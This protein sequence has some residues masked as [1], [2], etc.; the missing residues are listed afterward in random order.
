MT[1]GMKNV[2][3][4]GAAALLAAVA[5]PALPAAAQDQALVIAR[6]LE[7]NS[8]D[9]HRAFCDTCQI[10]LS[11]TYQ[12]LV[13]L[14]P[15]DR[16]LEPLLATEWSVNEEQTEYTFTL[17]PDA[18]FSDGSPVEAKDVK[19]TFERLKNLQ[20]NPSFMMAGVESIETPDEGT[21]VV[22][23]EAPNSEFLGILAAPYVGIVNS[24]VAMENGAVA[25]ED[26][27]STDQGEQWFLANSAGSGPY[28]L[29][30]YRPDDELRFRV[31]ENFWGEAPPISE[32]VID[33]SADAVSQAQMLQSGAADIAMQIDPDTASTISSPDI[34]IETVPSYNFIYV[35]F[36]P[37]AEG[38][39]VPL[40]LELR[41]ALAYAIDYEGAI[42]FTV[43]GE[44]EMQASPIPN[45]F[46]GTEGLPMPE[47][48]LEKAREILA[49]KGLED[50]FEVDATVASLNVYGV[51][52]TL[53]MQKMQQ[54]LARVNVKLNIQPV[55][56]A[57]WREQIADPGIPFSARFYAPDYYGSAQYVQFF[58]MIPG[59]YW[60]RNASGQGAVDLVNEREVELL[61]QA[62]AASG[63][64]M[65]EIYHEIALEMIKDRII[66]PVVSPNLVL[67]YRNNIEGVRYSVCCNLPLAEISRN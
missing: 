42:E 15:D 38:N 19:W 46:P 49:S 63:E 59:S 27:P 4:A 43:G 10:Y 2:P 12:G 3:L 37:G 64:E 44:G 26:A 51:D 25:G 48:N 13:K 23:M 29:A 32:I 8:L 11:A 28:V 45:G 55:A 62:L 21:V 58:G 33:H 66:V 53:L 40:D 7:I 47:E 5:A 6:N 56:S 16:S 39:T 20:G 30:N 17:D 35:V 67:A 52:L 65:N 14:A 50:G 54:D 22:N 24:D 57:V 36:S 18:V 34:T 31:N 61:E 9:P 41:Q 60:E 1:L